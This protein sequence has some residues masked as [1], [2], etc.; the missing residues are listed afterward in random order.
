MAVLERNCNEILAVHLMKI[1]SISSLLHGCEIWLL[2]NSSVHSAS[3]ALNKS[4]RKSSTAAGGKTPKLLL[5]YGKTFLIT[6]T[7][8]QHRIPFLKSKMPKQYIIECAI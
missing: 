7:V 2:K 1:Y 8:D 5:Y 4:F 3:V 6:N